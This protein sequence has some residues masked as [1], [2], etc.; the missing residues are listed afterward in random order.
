MIILMRNNMKKEI[1]IDT[2]NSQP[3]Y[4]CGNADCKECEEFMP[5]ITVGDGEVEVKCVSDSQEQENKIIEEFDEKFPNR[6]ESFDTCYLSG[7]ECGTNS[8]KIKSFILS[9]IK[10]AEDRKGEEIVE[11]QKNTPNKKVC[12]GCGIVGRILIRVYQDGSYDN[13]NL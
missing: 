9:K 5:K 6:F 7:S 8:T 4:G 10:E 2:I 11:I 3:F 12:V 1:Q 13:V